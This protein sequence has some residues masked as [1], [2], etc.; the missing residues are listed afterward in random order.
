MRPTTAA[1]RIP[2]ERR[3]VDDPMM[4]DS[5]LIH[6][7]AKSGNRLVG[8]I[9]TTGNALTRI[10]ALCYV[11]RRL[12]HHEQAAER[13][14]SLYESLYGS[15][16]PAVDAGRIQVDT[17]IM[18]HDAG[19]AS[20]LDRNADL[21]KA[22]TMLGKQASDRIIACVVLCVPCEEGVPLMPSGQR[23]QRLVGREVDALLAALDLLAAWWGFATKVA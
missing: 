1:A 19:V 22:M 3:T 21:G 13:F 23:N 8:K 20:R 2:I 11:R 6:Q 5:E 16:M 12:R 9:E 10:G 7:R 14:K 17:S 4:T 18:A 15:G